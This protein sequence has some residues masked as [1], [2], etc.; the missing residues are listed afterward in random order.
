MKN[1][2]ASKSKSLLQILQ[3]S[4]PTNPISKLK[5]N[6]VTEWVNADQNLDVTKT[7]TDSEIIEMVVHMERSAEEID[8]E[9][10]G[11]LLHSVW[12]LW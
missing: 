10:L 4:N 5:D 6:E 2:R 9:S 11:L 7:L 12:K 3:N 1:F 8:S